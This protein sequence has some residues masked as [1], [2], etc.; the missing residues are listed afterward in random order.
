MATKKSI[1]ILFAILIIAAW[2]LGSITEA[3]AQTYTMKCRETGH[4]PKVQF[5][6]V[7]DV[8]GHLIGVAE[9][10]GVLSCDDGSVA[11]TLNES[12]WDYI[13]GSGKAQAY[14]VAKYEDGSTIW[15]KFQVI[16]TAAADGKT[17]EWESTTSEFIRGTGR[18][19]GIQG[20]IS[21]I[22]KRLAPLPGAGS[23]YYIDHVFTYTLPSR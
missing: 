8:P 19:K 21:H 13:K 18:F 20:E 10:A 4:L 12:F 16:T 15:L 17:A 23:Q 3:G 2:L 22:G 11:T 5:L 1:R 14:W 9:L 6:E 7:G